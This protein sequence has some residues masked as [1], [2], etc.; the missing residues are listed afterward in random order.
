M[1]GPSRWVDRRAAVVLGCHRMPARGVSLEQDSRFSGKDA[2]LIKTTKFPAVFSE[3]VDMSKVNVSVMR[4]WIAT[5]VEQMMGFEDDILAELIMSLL[6]SDSHPDP[7]R[8]QITLTGFLEKRAAPFMNELWRLLLSAQ[9]S[10]GGVPRAFVEQ[11]KREMQAT[12]EENTRAMSEMQRRHGRDHSADDRP[13]SSRRWDRGRSP[14]ERDAPRGESWRRDRRDQGWATRAHFHRERAADASPEYSP[15]P[16][17]H[18]RQRSH[19][20]R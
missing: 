6:E 18:Y 4:P 12:R 5:R 3:R 7:R 20:P 19:S 9:A 8:M 1:R 17:T 2:S 11:K 14:I 13:K 15:P 10:V 16:P